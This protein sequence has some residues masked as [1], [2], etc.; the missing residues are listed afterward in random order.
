[1]H[2]QIFR[3]VFKALN[4]LTLLDQSKFYDHIRWAILCCH[5]DLGM[6]LL[7]TTPQD[8]NTCTTLSF[9]VRL[10]D[11]GGSFKWQL[12]I[13]LIEPN[14]VILLKELC[15]CYIL[16]SSSFSAFLL[17]CVCMVL[18]LCFLCFCFCCWI[19]M[20]W[21]VFRAWK[22]LYKWSSVINS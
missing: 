7:A 3:F 5:N 4:G 2:L 10:A 17:V 12:K 15:Q 11:S 21:T 18:N 16:K 1:M 20:Y 8:Y 19:V 22:V 13:F 6:L 14:L 9:N